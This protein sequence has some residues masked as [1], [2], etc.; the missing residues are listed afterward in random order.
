AS[1][2]DASGLSLHDALPF[3]GGGQDVL[4]RAHGLFGAFAVLG[5]DLAAAGHEGACA[6]GGI[7]D[8]P[9]GTRDLVGGADG[10]FGEFADLVGDRSEE[11]TSELQSRANLVCS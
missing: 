3:L 4:G 2:P 5:G 11:H 1:A 7:D 10:L 6:A 8:L 9:D